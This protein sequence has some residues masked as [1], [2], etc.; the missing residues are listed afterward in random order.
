[1]TVDTNPFGLS[2]NMVSVSISQKEK[3][4]GKVFGW[5]RKLEKKKRMKLGL[6]RR[7]FGE[8]W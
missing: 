6:L 2:I 4:G 8:Q 3:K 1:M 7:Q 5:E